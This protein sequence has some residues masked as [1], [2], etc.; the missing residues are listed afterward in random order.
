MN[1]KMRGKKPKARDSK[2]NESKSM[3]QRSAFIKVE[4]RLVLVSKKAGAIEFLET[5]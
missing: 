5:V 4:L 3:R 1:D 2:K